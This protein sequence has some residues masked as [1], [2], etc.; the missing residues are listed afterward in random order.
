MMAWSNLYSTQRPTPRQSFKV[1]HNLIRILKLVFKDPCIPFLPNHPNWCVPN[2]PKPF[3]EMLRSYLTIPTTKMNKH[4]IRGNKIN[5]KPIQD[6]TLNLRDNLT[7]QEVC[8]CLLPLSTTLF[9]NQF[10]PTLPSKVNK[11]FHHP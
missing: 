5:L 6:T 11:S 8:C 7:M 4:I 1:I 3:L 10:S 9:V 2:Q